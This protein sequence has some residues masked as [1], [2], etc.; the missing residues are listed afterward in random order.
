MGICGWCGKEIP[1][2]T[3]G[4]HAV[5]PSCGKSLHACV[6]CAF[7]AP[8]AWHDC[9][10]ASDEFVQD[11]QAPNLCEWFRLANTRRAEGKDQD[12]ARAKAEALFS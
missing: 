8:G 2:G 4:F 5:C 12:A 11:K 1:S 9:H 6:C 7:Y 3:I 10:A